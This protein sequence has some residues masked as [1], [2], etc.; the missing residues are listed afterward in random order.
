MKKLPSNAI[1]TDRKGNEIAYEDLLKDI[2]N[3]SEDTR[4]DIQALI[5][6]LSSLIGGPAEAVALMSHVTEMLNARIRNDDL[7]VKVAAIIARG[8]NAAKSSDNG[9][10]Y[11]IPEEERTQLLNEVYELAPRRNSTEHR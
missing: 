8:R 2:Y 7:L 6:Q 9:E 1:F 4:S 3:H 5:K 11:V 10:T